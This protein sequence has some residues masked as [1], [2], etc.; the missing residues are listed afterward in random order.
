MESEKLCIH[1]ENNNTIFIAVYSFVHYNNQ[2]KI[3]YRSKRKVYS[4]LNVIKFLISESISFILKITSGLFKF[5]SNWYSLFT[6]LIPNCDSQF[7]KS[8]N[9]YMIGQKLKTLKIQQFDC[10]SEYF[11]IYYFSAHSC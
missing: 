2:Y 7:S 1:I 8:F 4:F 10:H 3:V 11:Y 5:N 9:L 6:I